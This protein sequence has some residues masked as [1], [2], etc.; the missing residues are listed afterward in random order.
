MRICYEINCPMKSTG[1]PSYDRC[2]KCEPVT[3]V[4]N[5]T[6]HRVVC[7]KCNGVGTVKASPA[8]PS[9]YD[10]TVPY[11]INKPKS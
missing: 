8:V 11:G 3:Y 1:G 9:R 7:P 10:Y 2:P 4:S 6:E 5:R